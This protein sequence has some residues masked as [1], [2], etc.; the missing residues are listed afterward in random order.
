MSLS[1]ILLGKTEEM[2]ENPPPDAIP[3]S[4]FAVV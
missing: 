1:E 2:N 4:A 3:T